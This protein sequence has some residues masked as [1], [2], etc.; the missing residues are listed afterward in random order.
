MGGKKELR[1]LVSARGW[2]SKEGRKKLRGVGSE[3]RRK[4]LREGGGRLR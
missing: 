2:G 3:E 4:G 1:G